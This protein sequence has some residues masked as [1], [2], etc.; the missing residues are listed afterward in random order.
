MSSTQLLKNQLSQSVGRLR[1]GALHAPRRFVGACGLRHAVALPALKS[2]PHSLQ[3]IN[4]RTVQE[5]VEV[6]VLP[7]RSH[8]AP[9][10][11]SKALSSGGLLASATA[12][13]LAAS[14]ALGLPADAAAPAAD[15]AALSIPG[16]VGD[17]P[18]REGFVS[19]FLLIF[20]SEIG[21]KTFFIALLL[22]L[23]QP[24]GLVFTGTFGAL[25]VM[26]V[27][28]VLLGQ[29]LHQVD[30]LV[31][32]NG[33]GLP[34]DDLLAAALLLYF[35]FKTLQDAKDAGESA[36]E[37]KEEAQEVVDG[38]KSSSEDTL[39]LILTT[40]TLVFAAEWG[41][42]SFLATIALAA[43]S[44]PLGVTAGAVAGHGVA[45]GLAVAGGG[46]LSRYFSE[47]VLQYIGGS[48]FLVFAAATI[49]DLFV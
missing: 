25:A 48:L 4:E 37:E 16:I 24:K 40:F 22:A 33:A 30:E 7:A 26:T 21:D 5:P 28:S 3:R 9:S 17:S 36:A 15:T 34:Y 23:K 31:P 39:K 10:P 18:L 6:E 12:V 42:K 41:D 14:L 35:G 47:Q 1:P 19:G 46:F 2:V 32:E 11:L 38:L 44:S 13:A 20:F 43:A 29:V 27:V 45:T 49:V 8:T